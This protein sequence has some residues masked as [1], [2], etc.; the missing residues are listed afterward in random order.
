VFQKRGRLLIGAL[1]TLL[2]LGTSVGAAAALDAKD[3]LFER[4]R[5]VYDVVES[6]HKDGA[7][8]E[9]FTAGAI[10]GGLE[11]LGDPYTNYYSEEDYGDFLESLNGNFSGI[12]A[13]LEQADSYVVISS[14]IKGTPAAAAGL[15]SGDRILEVN[16]TP[17]VGSTTDKAVSLIRGP[18]GTEVTLKIERTS[19]KR[20]FTVTVKR[21]QIRIPEVETKML[22]GEVGYLQLSTF[23][24]DAA[25]SFYAGVEDLKSQGAKALVLDLRQN[26]GGYV[27]AAVDIASAF[28]PKGEPILWEVGKDGKSAFRSQGRLINLPTAVLV[29]GGSASASEIL[30]GAIQD[31]DAAELIGV[32]TFG[33]GTVQQILSLSIG[34]GMKV[35]VAE[36]LTGKERHVDKIGLTPDWVVENPKPDLSRT[37]PMKLNRLLLPDDIG[38]DVLDLQNRLKDLGYKPETTGHLGRNTREAAA[39]FARDNGLSVD[40]AISDQFIKVLNEQVTANAK[41][42]QQKDRQ[43]ERA[44]ELVR[45]KLAH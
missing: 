17:M 28:V 26:G 13:Y 27:N 38:L 31:Y 23:G 16:G 12:G 37:E 6:W 34:G 36:Y 18:E 35:T 19:E 4:I 21:A 32:K 33:K 22:D 29:D 44:V 41:Q 8:A 42:Q 39:Q 43:L 14:P 11:A 25:S 20:T 9:K 5:S 3:S 45:K 15:Q 10:K 2:L 24:D 7:D 30:A 1:A 40:H